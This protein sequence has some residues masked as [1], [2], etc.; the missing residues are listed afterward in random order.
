MAA[1]RMTDIFHQHVP[2]L[3]RETVEHLLTAKDGN[4]IDATYGRGSHTQAL[5][6]QLT[7]DARLL[8]FDKDL[9]AIAHAKEKHASDPRVQVFHGSFTNIQATV[10]E[11]GLLGKIDGVLF[12]LGV[13]S[14]QLDEAARGFSFS[15]EGPLDMRMNKAFG[16]TAEAWL[17]QVDEKRL[18][19]VLF[20]Y[21]EEK[22]SKRLAK[23]IVT[24]RGEKPFT[25]TNELADFI[26]KTLPFQKDKHPATRTFQA[27]RIVINEELKD[28]EMVLPQMLEVL[29]PNGR[30]AVISFHSLEDRIVKQ[31]IHRHEKE[32]SGP[33][34][35]PV[36]QSTFTPRIKTLIKPIRPTHEE[37]I[38]NPRARSAILRI[39]EKQS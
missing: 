25:K 21:G 6:Q 31:F 22:F 34:K 11:L 35:L 9:D 36:K 20:L 8:V 38:A 13:S 5:L 23:A 37:T 4:Y 1:C 19:E 27:I 2:V 24:R 33:R 7:K 30:F 15:K 14:P 12:D 39:A 16:I 29:R 10:Q 26:A 3:L 17:N 32:N 28:L 18:S